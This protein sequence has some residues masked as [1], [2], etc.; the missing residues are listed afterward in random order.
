MFDEEDFKIP[1]ESSLRLRVISDEI[2]NCT[3]LEG[4]RKQLKDCVR[5]TMQYQNML[6]KVVERGIMRDLE[7]WIGEKLK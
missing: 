4:M 5:M 7:D 2:D 3:D 1:I 6:T